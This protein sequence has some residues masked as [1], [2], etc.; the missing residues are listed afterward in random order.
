MAKKRFVKASDLYRIRQISHPEISPDGKYVVYA[1]LRVDRK[2]EKKYNNLWWISTGGGKARPFTTGD[3]VDSQPRWSPDGK[4]VAFISNRADEKQPQLYL[5]PANGGEARK[6]TNLKGEFGSFAWSPDGTKIVCPFRKKDKEVLK[7]ESDEQKKKLGIVYR[8]ITR[9]HYSLDGYG[10]LPKERWHLWIIDVATGKAKQI[11][12]GKVYDE[13]QPQ[14]SPD[15]ENIVFISNRSP[16]PDLAPDE[17][18][19]YLIPAKGG[20]MRKL[21]APLGPKMLPSF[22]PDGQLVAYIGHEGRGDWWKNERLWIV[23]TDGEGEARCLTAEHDVTVNTFTINDIGS[24]E[25]MPPTWSLDGKKLYFQ[26]SRHGSTTLNAINVEGGEMEEVIGPGGVVGTFTFD[27][28]QEQLA[29]FYGQMK[30]PA[31]VW[32]R[33][34]RDGSTR[35][36]TNLNAKLLEQWDLGE[37]EEVWFKGPD[38]NDLQ[39]WILK[40]PN[41]DPDKKYPAILEIHGGPMAQYGNF[42][43]HEFYYLAAQGYVVYFSNPRGGLGYGEAHAKAIWGGW[44]TADYADLMAWA[45][46][47]LQQPYIDRE[48]AGVT[49]GSY[50]GYMTAWIIG[51]TQRFKAA[52][53]QRSVTNC[54]SMW[55]SSDANWVFQ[56]PWGN[57]PPYESID[58]LWE[59][60]PMKHIGNARTPTLVIHSENDLRCPL[61][62]GQQ[63][64]VALKTLHV[65]TELILFPGEPHGLSRVGRTDKRIARLKHIRR[66]FNRYLAE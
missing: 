33:D 4:F 55:G 6:L 26:V 32:L 12:E 30:D 59:S 41:F 27:Q 29:F 17:D 22:S 45:D 58:A 7:R 42:F 25:P 56:M 47:V 60:S 3:H 63:L 54:V 10:F 44:G 5:I 21:N 11:T 24:A 50:G 34:M 61:E 15:G 2:T 49:G 8:R 52:V 53:A 66:W 13:R 57:K 64:Y 16:D 35:Q 37:I 51:H 46:Y 28:T 9:V 43:M 1:V 62:Q 48:R 38:D 36:L 14:W 65:D 19:V 20:E 18:D 23:P 40:P 39:G 31:Q